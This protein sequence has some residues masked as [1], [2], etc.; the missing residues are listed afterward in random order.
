VSPQTV[1]WIEQGRA[2]AATTDGRTFGTSFN[3]TIVFVLKEDG[4]K[5]LY[6]HTSDDNG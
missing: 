4:W 5:A 6:V 1:L 3:Q 2:E